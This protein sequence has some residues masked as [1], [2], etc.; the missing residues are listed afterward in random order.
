[1][2]ENKSHYTWDE[3][4]HDVDALATRIRALNRTFNGVYGPA[5]G[6][7][8]LAVSLSHALDIPLLAAPHDEN[9]LIVDDIADKGHT[10]QK[11]AGKNVIATIYHHPDCVFE[12]TIWLRK[13]GTEWILFPWE[14]SEQA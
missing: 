4:G 1:M 6:G 12:P 7:L 5:R 2:T 13:K 9:S 11:Y 10:L 8:P 14:K 3:F